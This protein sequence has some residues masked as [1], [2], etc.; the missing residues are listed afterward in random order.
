MSE[1][2][3]SSKALNKEVLAAALGQLP[4][5]QIVSSNSPKYPSQQYQELYRS[6]KFESFEA[7]MGFMTQATPIISQLDHHLRWENNWRTVAVWLTTWD[8]GHQISSLDLELA[9]QLTL[10]YQKLS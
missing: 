5:W 4:D 1:S 8:A 3:V 6:F 10:L 2:L 9:K 7:A